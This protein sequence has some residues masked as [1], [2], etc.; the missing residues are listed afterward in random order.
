MV[1]CLKNSKL[2][3]PGNALNAM[4]NFSHVTQSEE[5]CLYQVQERKELAN[6]C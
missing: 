1:L 2:T 6:I 5:R 3:T 4:L